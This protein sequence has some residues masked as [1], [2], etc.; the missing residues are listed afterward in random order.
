[1]IHTWF[2]NRWELKLNINGGLYMTVKIDKTMIDTINQML[3]K[4]KTIQMEYNHQNDTIKLLECKMKRVK[5]GTENKT[6]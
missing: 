5:I 1:M 4:G 2:A 6:K 3:S